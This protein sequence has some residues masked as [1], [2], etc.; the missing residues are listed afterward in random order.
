MAFMAISTTSNCF[1]PLGPSEQYFF[2][3]DQNSAKHFVIA[4]EV[5]GVATVEAWI[6]A[7]AAAQ[8]RHPLLRVSVEYGSEGPPRFR[9]HANIPIPV[10]IL[11]E[12]ESATWQVE[13]AK[14]LATPIPPSLHVSLSCERVVDQS[15]F[16]QCIIPLRMG[17]LRLSSYGT[18]LKRSHGSLFS[19]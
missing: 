18:S 14:E 11:P 10:R 12:D 16:L 4:A 15:F 2:L 19:H 3:S 9:E 8:V 7:V 5:I 17:C 6:S 1:R 13:M